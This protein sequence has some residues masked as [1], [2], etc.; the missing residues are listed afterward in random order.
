MSK[1]ILNK[2]KNKIKELGDI[3]AETKINTLKEE[4]QYYVLQFIYH[5]PEYKNWIMYGGSAL[6]IMHGLDRMSVDLDFEV[7]F[8]IDDVFLIKLKQ[9]IEDYF[10]KN[11]NA[12]NDFLVVKIKNNRGILLKFI[13]EDLT[14]GYSSNQIHLKI[15]LNFFKAPKNVVIERVPINHD[16]LSFVILTYNM[17]AL[18]ASKIVAIFLRGN[19]IVGGDIFG[20]KGRDIYDLLWY[21]NKVIVPDFDYLIAKGIEQK[22]PRDLFNKLSIRILNRE[23][24]DKNL[25]DDLT[26]LFIDQSYIENWLKNWRETYVHLLKKY[27]IRTIKKLDSIKIFENFRTDNF[28]FRYYYLTEEGDGIEIIYNLSDYWITFREGKLSIYF[29][30]LLEDK[31]EF[32]RSGWSSKEKPYEELK[33][34]ATL[35]F[36]KNEKYFKK[37][38]NVI[39]GDLI[40]TKLIRMTASDLNIQKEILL[41]KSSLMSCDLDDL[42]R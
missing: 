36:K 8:K 41:P 10:V 16:Q 39:M 12:E 24:T 35:F 2:L 27:K 34:Y 25:K 29:D 21:M 37:M 22:N 15:D 17:S 6:R 9:E 33:K 28:S 23:G 3:D 20:E 26:P 5:H 42:L 38:N 32:I 14:E 31:I 30:E 18:M 4:L 11:Y 7:D 1:Q 40:S 19:R 13:N